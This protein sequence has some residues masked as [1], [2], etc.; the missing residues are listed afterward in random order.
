[1]DAWFVGYQ[2]TIV[3]AAWVGYDTPRNLGSRETGGGLSLPIWIDFMSEALKGVPVVEYTPPAGVIHVG[4]E[5]YYEEYGPG[6]GVRGLGLR[7]A[8]PGAA[9][10]GGT[11]SESSTEGGE[12]PASEAASEDRRSILDLFKN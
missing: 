6:H 1:M 2:P 12:T 3:A 9:P 11:D 8:W 4:N 7:D 5:W 10:S